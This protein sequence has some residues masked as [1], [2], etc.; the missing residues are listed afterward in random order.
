MNLEESIK[1]RVGKE[2][3]KVNPGKEKQ[4][5]QTLCGLGDLVLFSVCLLACS[6]TGCRERVAQAGLKC[7]AN[8]VLGF[9]C[10]ASEC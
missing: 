1:K 2:T 5:R 4:R 7:V 6:L 8:L 10:M 9:L 3:C